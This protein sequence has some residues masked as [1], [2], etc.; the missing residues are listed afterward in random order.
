HPV[1]VTVGEWS[2]LDNLVVGERGRAGAGRHLPAEVP[3]GRRRPGGTGQPDGSGGVY[4]AVGG[5]VV[6]RH[7]DR[8]EQPA[9][10]ADEPERGTD[11]GQVAVWVGPGVI[12]GDGRVDQPVSGADAAAER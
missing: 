5:E 2:V 3:V 4:A 1:L 9:A 6:A 8:G 11:L 7:V 12:E 10:G